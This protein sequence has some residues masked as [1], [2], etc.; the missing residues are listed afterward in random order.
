MTKLEM[1]AEEKDALS[2][3]FWTDARN[4]GRTNAQT[5]AQEQHLMS[6]GS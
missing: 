5:D 6:A 3:D 2:V 1:Y 4:H